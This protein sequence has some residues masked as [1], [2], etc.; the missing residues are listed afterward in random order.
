MVVAFGN[1][2]AVGVLLQLLLVLPLLLFLLVLLLLLFSWC[3]CCWARGDDEGV[4]SVGAAPGV[5]AAAGME[6]KMR[7]VWGS[8][9][10]EGCFGCREEMAERGEWPGG[11]LFLGALS[12]SPPFNKTLLVLNFFLSPFQKVFPP[13]PLSPAFFFFL[14][15]PLCPFLSLCFF[16]VFFVSSP[17][18]CPFPPPSSAFF[19]FSPLLFFLGLS[20]FIGKNGAGAPSITQRLVGQ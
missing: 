20:L 17:L 15:P 10:R 19:F 7:S 12:L 4:G 5:A 14:L 1:A 8:V 6:E 11:G 18:F 2:G 16:S 9:D 13:S 3:C